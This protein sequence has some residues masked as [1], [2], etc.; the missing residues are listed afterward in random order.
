MNSAFDRER[1]GRI[2]VWAAA[3]RLG[4][5]SEIAE[6]AAE[7]EEL[8]YGTAWVPGVANPGTLVACEPLLE[9]TERMM[10]NTGVINIWVEEPDDVAAEFA[11]VTSKHGDRVL[12]GLGISHGPLIGERYVKPLS[13]MRE[14]L[15]QLEAADPPLDAEGRVLAA[16]GPKM[17][18]LARERSVGSHP[19]LMPPE[20]TALAR[21]ALGED[22]LLAPEQTVVLETDPERA[23]EV[24]RKWLSI[25]TGLPNYMENLRRVLDLS[26]GDFADGGSDRLIDAAVAWGDEDAIRKRVDEHFQAGADH[27]CV[28]VVAS[29][30]VLPLDALRRLAPALID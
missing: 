18:E 26:D 3:W 16:I 14:Y 29:A 25:Y 21:E 11:R 8:G 27:V 24:A 12:A 30:K 22:R 5:P 13:K 10:V 9:A 17:L 7:L 15:D 6:G 1:L 23:R 2:G 20:H 19:Y 4:E 28:Q